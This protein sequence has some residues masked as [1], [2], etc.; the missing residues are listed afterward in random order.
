[1]LAILM[2]WILIHLLIDQY[3]NNTLYVSYITN[4]IMGSFSYWPV[5]KLDTMYYIF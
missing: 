4:Q 1:M 3:L 2:I 5:N